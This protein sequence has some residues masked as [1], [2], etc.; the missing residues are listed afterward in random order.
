MRASSSVF[1]WV[2]NASTVDLRRACSLRVAC[3]FSFSFQKD[4]SPARASSS[5]IFERLPATS[6]MPPENVQAALQLRDTFSQGTDF[7]GAET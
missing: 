4:G 7:H 2:S 1:S 5:A 6:K 3:A